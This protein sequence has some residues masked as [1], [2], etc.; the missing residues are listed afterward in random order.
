VD[1]R[2]LPHSLDAERAVLGAVLIDPAMY[3]VA[4][5]LLH[6]GEFYRAAHARIW[7]AYGRIR[8]SDLDLDFI[9]LRSDLDRNGTL[10]DVGGLAYLSGLVDGVPR[11]VN[12]ESY[13]AIVREKSQRRQI[14]AA[15]RLTIEDVMSGDDDATD[16]L[17]QAESRLMGISRGSTGHDFV[18]ASDW[19]A[20]VY[21]RIE[22]AIAEKRVVSGV[23]TG[24]NDLDRLTRGFQ[25]SELIIIAAR[26]SVGKTALALQFAAYASKHAF[27]GIVSMEMSLEA[28]GFRAIALE[29]NLSMFRLLTGQLAEHEIARV[30]RAIQS[31]SEKRIA[32]DDEAGQN[33]SALC[34]KVR[35]LVSRHGAGI[36]FI[37]YL[38][39]MNG[40]KSRSE[41]RTQEVRE[42]SGRLKA[43]AK[44][45][46][47]PIVVLSQ[48]SRESAKTPGGRPQ[49]HH[50]RDGGDIEQDADVVILIHRPNRTESGAYEDGEEVELL[51]EKQ[52]QGP[53][54]VTVSAIWNGPTM[55]FM[56][57]PKTDDRQPHLPPARESR[58]P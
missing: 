11:S 53:A 55:S 6:A 14:I 46:K 32:V 15:A 18:L 7:E 4:S 40:T 28:V 39:L 38:Q 45:L 19:M 27:V 5:S 25:P 36:V 22:R 8:Q 9:T 47:I 23:P 58:Y 56:D 17:N 21:P 13:A 31:L 37:D 29:A 49:L 34:S 51:L 41:N 20:G 30:G 54:R 12:V 24:L 44:E 35:R 16:I 52:R 26:P 33:V 1:D 2:T 10:E 57:K 50:L 43:L 42:I 3:D 48:L